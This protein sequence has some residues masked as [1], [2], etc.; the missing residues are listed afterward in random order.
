MRAFFTDLPQ[1][2]EQA[3]R[4]DGASEMQI[5]L[6]VMLPLVRP[7]MAALAVFTFLGELEQLPGPAALP[8]RAVS[9]GR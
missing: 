6:R 8:A 5:F 9:T 4:V 7:G 3:A 1:E 2:L